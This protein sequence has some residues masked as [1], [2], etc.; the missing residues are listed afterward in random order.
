MASWMDWI[1]RAAAVLIPALLGL[2]AQVSGYTNPDLAWWLWTLAAGIAVFVYGYLP[3]R[4][5][6]HLSREPQTLMVGWGLRWTPPNVRTVPSAIPSSQAPP[7]IPNKRIEVQQAHDAIALFDESGKALYQ[8]IQVWFVNVDPT[9]TVRE[10][11]AEISWSPA[12]G[13]SQGW[14]GAFGRWAIGTKPENVGG[15]TELRPKT[16][17]AP[18]AVGKLN[19][20]QR[21]GDGGLITSRIFA[22][23]NGIG[24]WLR[25]HAIGA[26]DCFVHIQL[27]GVGFERLFSFR[28][29]NGATFALLPE[30]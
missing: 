13:G 22:E 24:S 11:S 8:L 21:F 20:F 6:L 25:E 15:W 26:H 7:V 29:L 14:T 16:D 23:T 19:A 30:N 2:G 4:K 1:V 9:T 27:R 3:A 17:F 12:T 5:R 18:G 10:I 28:L